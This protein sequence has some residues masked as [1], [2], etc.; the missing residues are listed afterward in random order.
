MTD[1][2]E[3]VE[4]TIIYEGMTLRFDA[5]LATLTL[6]D[7]DR[8][9]ALSAAMALGVIEA[10]TELS[11]PRRGVRA[12]LI[13]GEGRGFCA[14][15]NLAAE[16]RAVTRGQGKAPAINAVETAF[17]PMLRRLHALPVPVI[18]A[19]NGPCLGIGLGL[20]LA[21]D[22][23]IAS[24]AAY[25]QAPFRN[26]AS[27]SDSGL[28][29]LLPRLVGLQ[30]AR[31]LLLGAERISS[32]EALHLG[33]IA[34]VAPEE[35]FEEAA[36]ARAAAFAAGPTIALM[37]IKRLLADGLSGE[38]DS[39]FEAEARAV[40]RTGRT[41]DNLAAMRLFGTKQAPEFTGQ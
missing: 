3:R 11:K 15:A 30:A 9:N 41:K 31:R 1:A 10:L 29:W 4:E 33:L 19:V 16:A 28:T 24:E 36:L 20:A 37:E 2:T 23:I 32:R 27:A 22:H 5:A 40:A 13:R 14:G 34:E 6:N 12:L 21:A 17:H 7:P 8:L 25:F 35:G 26:L 38:L 39:A 18:A